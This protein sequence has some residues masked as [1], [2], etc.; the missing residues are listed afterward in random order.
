[1]LELSLGNYAGALDHALRAQPRDGIVGFAVVGDLA[2][3]AARSE[4][5]RTAA[6]VLARFAPWALASGTPW[7]LGVLARC[8]ALLA[9]GEDAQPDYLLAIEN[10]R[11]TRIV[12]ELAR[13]H[14]VYGEWLRRQRRRRAARDQLH[15]A[16][17]IFDRLGMEAF[18]E[19]ARAELRATGE[20]AAKRTSGTG[21]DALTPQEAQIARLAGEGATNAEIAARLF[22]SVATVD[23]HLRKVFR[24]L[25]ITRRVELA[26]QADLALLPGRCLPVLNQDLVDDLGDA[27]RAPGG[28]H[29]FVALGP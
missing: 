13:T 21:D 4:D 19:R 25:G 15:T 7:A 17:G 22:I 14:L 3:A 28:G 5:R 26:R 9:A 6:A 8:R 29:G 12:P 1:M 23:Y 10:L 18:A 20:H 2:E 11:Q 27:R 16:H 24:K